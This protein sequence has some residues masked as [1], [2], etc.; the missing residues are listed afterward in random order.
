MLQTP[1]DINKYLKKTL[2]QKLTTILQFPQHKKVLNKLKK[3][4]KNEE[5]KQYMKNFV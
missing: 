1:N 2:T 5:S 4:Q 3:P